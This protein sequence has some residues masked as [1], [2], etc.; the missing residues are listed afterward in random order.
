M[1]Q[2]CVVILSDKSLFI[3][4]VASRLQQYLQQ[5]TIQFIDPR[6]PDV[7]TK[8]IEAQP[9]IVLI[10]STGSKKAQW[11][12]LHNLIFLLPSLK[13]IHLDLQQKQ[14]QVIT[15]KQYLVKEVRDLLGVIEQSAQS[16]TLN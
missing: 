15:S 5:M 1:T 8:L 12:S 11:C 3:E 7:I 2:N 9:S 14:V 16:Y 10:D 4:G 6:Q 13:I